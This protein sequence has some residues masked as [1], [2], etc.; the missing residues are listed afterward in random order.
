MAYIQR[1]IKERFEK[2][3]KAYN[4]V[5]LVGARQSGKT[6]FLKEEIKG[7]RSKYILFDDPDARALF[8]SDIKSFDMQYI[9]GN[10]VTML[11]EV[12]YCR[13]AGAKLK[14]LVDIGRKLW[15][16]SSSEIML[17]KEVL[18]FLVGRV[19]IIR[20]YPFSLFEFMGAKGQKKVSKD[21]LQRLVWEQMAYGSYPKVV[22]SDDVELKKIILSDLYDTM[23]FKDIVKVFSIDDLKSLEQ[24]MKYLSVNIGGV[25]SYES[26]SDRLNMSFVTLKKYLDALEKSYVIVRVSPFFKNRTKEITKQPKIYFID[27]GLRNF[28]AKQFDPESTGALFENYVLMELVKKG[29]EVK[30]W[31]TKSGTEVDFVIE[32]DRE[33]IPVEV[34]LSADKNKVESNLKSFISAYKPKRA[35]VVGYR[36]VKGE[37]KIDGCKVL[38]GDVQSVLEE[39]GK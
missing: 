35:F 23:V 4:M 36:C 18:S 32:K 33:I 8:E 10:E 13:D 16:T 20:L 1:G 9:S 21:I 31:R 11:D 37:V 26:A 24:L 28:I 34:K 3:S 5:A 12:Q 39:I 14:Y 6:T 30:Y 19:S 17:S 25:C 2:V 15:I 38:I 7:K 27:T 22:L 29:L